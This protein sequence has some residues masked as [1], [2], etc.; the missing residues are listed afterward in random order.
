MATRLRSL[1][2]VLALASS[3]AVLPAH[4]QSASAATPVLYAA[5]GAGGG[6][7]SSTN[8]GGTL[9]SLYTLDP[10]TAAATLVGPITVGGDQVRHVTGLGVDPATG[11]LYGFMNGQDT[12]VDCTDFAQGTLVTIDKTSGAATIVGSQ[13]D[14]P[15]QSPD[16]TFDPLG[17][18]YA[19][20]V[21]ESGNCSNNA[22][23]TLNTSTG[24]GTRV[25]GCAC[26]YDTRVGISS[27]SKGRLFVKPDNLLQRL[28]RTTGGLVG[29]PLSLNPNVAYHNMLAFGPSDTLYTG[30]RSN[31]GLALKTI[32]TSTGAVTTVGSN[33]IPNISALAW[34]FGTPPGTA[35][36]SITK[37]VD[38][39][40]PDPETP[41][42]F[43]VTVSN[44]GPDTATGVVVK[45]LLPSGF[46]YVSDDGLGAYNS[47]TGIWT[48]GSIAA[49][50]SAALEITATYH[51]SGNH[52]N[53]AEV[54]EDETFDPDSIPGSGEGDTYSAVPLTPTLYAA[55]GSGN[56]SDCSGTL[57][58]LYS[59]DAATGAA[60]RIGDIT[61]GGTRVRHVTGL[62][63]DPTT[64]TLYGFMNGQDPNCS[65]FATG[66]LLTIDKGT[67]V[68]TIVG[69]QGAPSLQVPDMSFDPFGTLYAFGICDGGPSGPCRYDLF[70]LNKTNGTSTRVGECSC[71][72][73]SYGLAVDSKGKMYLKPGTNLDRVNQFTGTDFDSITLSPSG[74][75]HNMLAFGPGDTLYTGTRSNTGLTL[76]TIDPSNGNV[77]PIGSNN[78]TNISALAW[79]L[80][81]YT[82]PPV[83][84]LSI[85]KSVDDATPSDFYANVTFTITISNAGPDTATG[86]VGYDP[87]PSGFTYVSDDG[88]GAYDSGTG[89]WTVG[90]IADE[91]TATLHIVMSV[92]PS[93]S[94]TNAA[95]VLEA[96]TY[97]PDSVPSSVEGDAVDTQA[98]TPAADTNIDAHADVIV[99]GGT[100]ASATAQ[101]F[102]VVVINAGESPL[103]LSS[104]EIEV[105]VNGDGSVISCD[106]F[107]PATVK[108]ASSKKVKCT[109]NIAGLGLAPGDPVTYSATVDVPSDGF[110]A[111]DT[112]SVFRTL[113]SDTFTPPGNIDAHADVIVKGGTVASATAQKFSVVVINAGEAPLP[114]SPGDIE[115]TVND[116]ASVISCNAFKPATV[117]SGSSKKVKC[118]A[119]IAGLGLAPGDPV[120]YSATVDVPSDGSAANDTDSVFRTLT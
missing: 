94:H 103:P 48:V 75:Y 66:T 60:T 29:A 20:S 42:T 3:V 108:S 76:K 39:D 35:D 84:N 89:I 57:S 101:K 46:T 100:L 25:G 26:S 120:T 62:A 71:D 4:L 97:D 117:K 45:D 58:S 107:T 105:T 86:V 33:N 93:G 69:S 110:T 112:D 18:L 13:G 50:N 47:T 81:T 38:D 7:N 102:T 59:L 34:D 8:C 104:N 52:T 68:A 118:T 90:S 72:A 114:L 116:D 83:A 64:G 111:N 56:Q 99:K 85:D 31:T 61:I 78:V 27:D 55:T 53:V 87:I 67:G 36:L 6:F 79:D 32:D 21:C 44:G 28:D 19:W 12:S 49:S 9:S 65:D 80:G 5:T 1:L 54:I 92:L 11:T 95:E 17:R 109:A 96:D 91:E 73:G 40:T 115:V 119:N 63:V 77:T 23:W 98:V 106:A 24:A 37:T 43:T 88:G 113:A 41:V 10:G 16:M 82:P 15:I 14:V 30:I 22:L 70:K 74:T 2:V 51:S